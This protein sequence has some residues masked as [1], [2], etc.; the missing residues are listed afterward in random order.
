LIN[1][2]NVI[3]FTGVREA[4][5]YA[6]IDSIILTPVVVPEE[7]EEPIDPDSAITIQAE[8]FESLE[9]YSVGSAGDITV[10][11]INPDV[12]SGSSATASTS[13]AGETGF[14]TIQVQ[15]LD[16]NDGEG[17]I[18]FSIN[19]AE[20]DSLT[21]DS[22]AG[23]AL[24]LPVSTWN[25][26]DG[27]SILINTGDIIKFT[28]R[29]DA[30]EYARI[31]AI[32]LTPVV[33]PEEP[34]DP[35]RPE[36]PINPTPEEPENP[37]DGSQTGLKIT[38]DNLL[39]LEN[40]TEPQNVQFS[41]V[42]PSKHGAIEIGFFSVD[43]EQGSISGVNPGDENYLETA[44]STAKT[45]FSTLGDLDI[46]QLDLSRLLTLE[47]G[48]LISFFVIKNG[49]LDSI[50]SNGTGQLILGSPLLNQA[51]SNVVTVDFLESEEAY[52]FN[53]ELNGDGK[54]DDF[55]LKIEPSK[56]QAA[57]LGSNLQGG[58]QSELLDLRNLTGEAILQLQVLREA[59][60]NNKLGF[61]RV[62]NEQ[63]TVVDEFG[64]ALNPGES[65]Y[66]RAAIQ[67]WVG[68]PIISPANRST[69][70]VTVSVAGG[71]ILA[72]F[73]ITNGTIEQLLDTDF[74]NDPAVFFPFLGANPDSVDHVKLLGDNTFGFED[75]LGGGDFDY[76]DLVVKVTVQPI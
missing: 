7:P 52:V 28:G 51:A 18:S 17:S 19:D 11:R 32:V 33:A 2:G 40:E 76:D 43:D 27:D 42:E 66:V 6:R 47:P 65:G 67:Q 46:N 37:G 31:D 13:F 29:R 34:E 61:Y 53:W 1:T 48:K 64:N 5:E 36:V 24:G 63:G 60:S 54:F 50:L 59:A 30:E 38:E 73:M 22:E 10:I 16:E 75:W 4:E 14:Y 20:V 68:E 8:D 44:L 23:D 15:Y 12:P 21:L 71:Q 45:I 62:E 69:I 26:N 49:T 3:E 41:I 70:N 39:N 35:N 57:P 58:Q 25:I 56:G 72:P 55:S 9:G 74:T